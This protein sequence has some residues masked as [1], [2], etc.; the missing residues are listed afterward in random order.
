[1]SPTVTAPSPAGPAPVFATVGTGGR[2][3][4]DISTTDPEA[5]YFAALSAANHNPSHGHLSLSV[6]SS[7]LSAGFVSTTGVSV[8]R[9][10]ITRDSAAL[11]DAAAPA[12]VSRTDST[13]VMSATR[14][15]GATSPAPASPTTSPST[16]TPAT[17]PSATPSAT[18][19]SPGT[20]RTIPTVWL[21]PPVVSAP[22]GSPAPGE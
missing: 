15:D 14:A 20:P 12:W 19:G 18:A 5:G 8:D 21:E 1:M 6:T 9:F 10:T 13:T 22:V 4:R 16:S 11:T 3:L 17:T 2:A 7:T